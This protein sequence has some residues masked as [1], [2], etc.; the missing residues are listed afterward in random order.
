M[1]RR[2]LGIFYTPSEATRILC[3]W[4]I[5]T[6]LDL[7]L[8]PSFGACGFLEASRSRLD[9]L[10]NTNPAE[11]LFG[12]DIDPR[13]FSEFLIPKFDGYN[14]A[15]RF[16]NKDFLSI[17]PA[18]FPVQAFDAII[19]NPPYVSHHH[20]PVLR[21]KSLADLMAVD[22]NLDSKSSLWA[23]FI[24]H[25]LKFLKVGGRIAW[26]LPSSFLHAD[27]SYAIRQRIAN[28][29]ER[30][31]IIQLGQRLFASEGTEESTAVL[32]AEGWK[33]HPS[34]GFARVDFAA[35]LL[36][37]ERTI[38]RWQLG[39]A[40]G[41]EYDRRLGHALMP[42]EAVRAVEFIEQTH[43][44]RKLGSVADVLIGLVTGAN[45]FFV[46][47]EEI[48]K[49]WGL[50]ES[51]LRPILSKASLFDGIKITTLDLR[52]ASENNVRCLLLNTK[53]IR[54]EDLPVRVYLW[55][56]PEDRK[57]A[58]CTFGKRAIWHQSDDGRIPHAFF[59]YVLQHGPR[60]I[61]N[62]AKTTCTNSVHRVF[63]RDNVS[64]AEMRA[65]AISVLSTYSQ[66]SAE[67]EGRTYGVGALKLEPSEAKRM[68]LIMPT[69]LTIQEVNSTFK[70]IDR[71]LSVGKAHEATRI[72]DAFVMGRGASNKKILGALR[73][74]LQGC[75][76]R[77]YESTKTCQA[78]GGAI[79]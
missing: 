43:L 38:G 6:P 77:R 1:E 55:S 39:E 63:F 47:N 73:Q 56:F 46:I 70:Q 60:L 66:L 25:S 41:S 16:K 35:T 54:S 8:E 67:V 10:A 78:T 18:E 13:A 68:G 58:N 72:A 79:N 36:D 50:G 20:I 30:T 61:L 5:R 21:K 52:K 9:E 33:G 49:Q 45:D 29:F 62:V 40:V 48:A 34:S 69:K 12:C 17:T 64:P 37:L 28:C 26:I 22:I 2:E 3:N 32:L 11:N 44:V 27:Y 71:L 74:A 15:S 57:F 59:P 51:C 76:T 65:A 31:L 4:A 23:Y 14:L 19:G 75:R 53:N 24:L 42:Q 7:V